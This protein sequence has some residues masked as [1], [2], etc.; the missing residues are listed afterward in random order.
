MIN[1]WDTLVSTKRT[2]TSALMDVSVLLPL[3]HSTVI[4]LSNQ[5]MN[6]AVSLYY[7]LQPNK[8]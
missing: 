8:K 5:T 6:G 7:T 3:L 1:I 4:W 2:D